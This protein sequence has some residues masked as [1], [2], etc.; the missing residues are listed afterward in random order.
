MKTN[1]GGYG[2]SP[3]RAKP[4]CKASPRRGFG[5]EQLAEIS[6]MINAEKSDVFD[7]LA[8]IAFA[9]APITRSER[10]EARKGEIFTR[11]DGKLQAF[12]DFVLAQYV[13]QGVGELDQE[14]LGHL[15]ELK[16]HTVSD[17]ADQLGGS[18][19]DSRYVHRLPAISV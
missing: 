1:F 12:L 7:V 10:V 18:A 11:Y 19:G 13:K 9:L 16:Y 15:L 14:K 3:I 17:A 4:C 2:A 5:P 8:Y 6:R